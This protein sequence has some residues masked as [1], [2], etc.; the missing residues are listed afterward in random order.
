MILCSGERREQNSW[1]I[2]KLGLSFLAMVCY[3]R[4]T[5]IILICRDDERILTVLAFWQLYFG[6]IG[7]ENH[8]ENNGKRRVSRQSWKPGRLLTVLSGA[9][10]AAYSVIKIAIAAVVTVLLIAGV[11]VAVFAGVLADYLEGDIIPQAGVQLE[12]FDLDQP[13]YIYYLDDAG[14]IQVL[15]K[16]YADTDSEWAEFEEIPQDMIHAAVAIEDHRFFEHQGVDWF[17]TIKACVGMFV[18]GNGAGGSSITQQLIKNMLLTTDAS[19]DDQT[20]QRKVLEIFRATEFEKQY[21]KATVLEWYLNYIYLGN[22]CKGVKAAAEKYFGKELEDLTAAEC[23]CIISITNNPSIYDPLSDKEVYV[24]AE[25]ETHTRAEWNKIRRENVLWVM[26]NYGYLTEDEYQAALTESENLTFKDGIDFE[27]KYSDC[28]ECG[29]HAHNDTYVLNGGVYYCPECGAATTIGENASQDVYSWFVDTVLEDVATEMATAAGYEMSDDVMKLYKNLICKG[30]YHIYSTFD[31]DAQTAVDDIYTNLD[32]IPTTSSLQQLESGIILIDNE[33]GDIIAMSGGVGEKTVFDAYNRATDAMLQPGSSIKPLSIYAPAFELGV[34]SPVSV[35]ADLPIYYYDKETGYVVADLENFSGQL[36]S[37]PKNDNKSYS[38]SYSIYQG[39]VSSVNGVAVN[40]LS[41]MGLEYSFNFAKNKFHLDTLVDSYTTS[42]GRVLTDIAYS[43]LGMGAP[44]V[45]V[46]VRDMAEAYATFAN[47]GVWR[48]ART[49][50]HVYNTDGELVCY[51]R[52]ES[53]SI[54]SEKTVTYINY[55]LTNAVKSGTGTAAQV[56]GQMVAGKTGTTSSAKDRW[57]CGFTDYYTAAI[58]CGY[59]TPEVMKLTGSDT[60]NPACRL[61][62]KVMAPL[63]SGLESVDVYDDSQLISVEICKDSGLLATEGCTKDCRGSRVVKAS[64]LAEDIPTEYCDAHV[65]VDY[66]SECGAPANEY[67]YKYAALG[68]T[69]ITT[70]YLVKLTQEDVDEI[71]TAC[72]H[73]LSKS[74]LS[75]DYIY[76]VDDYGNPAAFH[77][78]YGNKNLGLNYPYV[79]GTKHNANTWESYLKKHPEAGITTDETTDPTQTADTTDATEE[80]QT[81]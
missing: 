71:V 10:T 5:G 65:A 69:Q 9:W 64:A 50:T 48:E 27:D 33:T 78:I 31:L 51:N 56:S 66:C 68:K 36:S 38:Y 35:M 60:R 19:A 43:P 74:Y 13:S 76:L 80:K 40:T 16:L 63:H 67:C 77:G 2:H 46:T 32:E 3:N 42:S 73:G 57:F 55:C 47:N 61:F 75:N 53:D 44:T 41:T 17:T 22:R 29:Y 45:G 8:N 79:V 18:G 24:K 52:Q 4:M 26:R 6:G 34:I 62:A 72:S 70:V 54:I 49:F 15:Q 20:V 1:I 59:D 37:F 39:I 28:S 21:D 25:D 12:G 58:W 7:M 81:P 30:G 11:C 14:N 23:A